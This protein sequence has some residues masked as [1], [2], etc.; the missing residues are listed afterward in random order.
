MSAC[1]FRVVNTDRAVVECPSLID[2]NLKKERVELT[3]DFRNL[4]GKLAATEQSPDTSND[5]IRNY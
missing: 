2:L 4:Q 5:K 3:K 1:G